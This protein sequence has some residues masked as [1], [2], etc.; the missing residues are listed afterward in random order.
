M[1]GKHKAVRIVEHGFL[2]DEKDDPILCPVRAGNCTVKCAWFSAEDRI[3]RCQS[4]IIGAL[5]G[6]GLRSFRLHTGPGVY[7]VD[8][9]LTRHDEASEHRRAGN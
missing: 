1:I 6:K 8:E 3:L 5:R 7:N 9:A 4:T 2:T